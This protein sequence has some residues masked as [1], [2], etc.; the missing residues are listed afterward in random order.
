[1]FRNIWPGPRVHRW[2]PYLPEHISGQLAFGKTGSSYKEYTEV[3]WQQQH[4]LGMLE[5]LP[6]LNEVDTQIM[7]VSD[8]D[9]IIHDF[10][11]HGYAAIALELAADDFGSWPTRERIYFAYLKGVDDANVTRLREMVS[12]VSA[13]K[14]GAGNAEDYILGTDD[15]HSLYGTTFQ[16]PG[17]PRKKVC[18]DTAKFKPVH[19]EVFTAMSI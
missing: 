4:E 7:S 5:N 1:M 18:V 12:W 9:W 14:V 2:L 8:R 13:M 16:E 19:E 10:A 15:M 6:K 17:A 11:E 3:V